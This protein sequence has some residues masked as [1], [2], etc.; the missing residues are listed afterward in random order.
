M[1][2][3]IVI[4]I[5]IASNSAE[6]ISVNVL[7]FDGMDVASVARNMWLALFLLDGLWVIIDLLRNVAELLV[8]YPV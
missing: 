1:S 7:R 8:T 4:G 3:H 6:C 5:N 2:F